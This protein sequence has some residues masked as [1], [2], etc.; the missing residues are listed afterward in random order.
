MVSETPL[1][2]ILISMGLI[3]RPTLSK[4]L[5]SQRAQ[6]KIGLIMVDQQLITAND[7]DEA[8]RIQRDLKSWRRNKRV[9]ARADIAMRHSAAVR[10]EAAAIGSYV[11][12]ALIPALLAAD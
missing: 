11:Q 9:L 12:S 10:K 8:L 1:G 3:D 6:R 5:R 2:D 4:V 7:L